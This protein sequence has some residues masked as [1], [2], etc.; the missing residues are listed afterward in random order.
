M[1]LV[2]NG[3]NGLSDVDGS[4]ATP[5]IRG[6]DANTGIF[7]PAADTIAFSEGGTE[8]MRID[9]S[10]NVG[11]GTAVAGAISPSL[12]LG[13]SGS[14]GGVVTA[15][16]S[17]GSYSTGY[18]SNIISSSD[19]SSSSAS[20]LAFGTTATGASGLS[21]PVE[22]MRID[23]SGN[24]LVGTT[25]TPSSGGIGIGFQPGYSTSGVSMVCRTNTA[26]NNDH[27]YFYTTSGLAGYIRTNGITTTYAS[28]SD[29][30]LKENIADA[31][32]AVEKVQQIQVR[33]FDWKSGDGHVDYGFIAQEL[34]LVAPQAVA[35]GTEEN[36]VWAVDS[37]MLV[38]LLVKAIQEQQAL[39]ITL[40]DRIT[41]L[42]AKP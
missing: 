38:P 34:N 32:S 14:G 30:R 8:A 11:V 6:T 1:T 21:A 13:N 19:F 10:G 2:L 36:D 20:Y 40:T 42:E 29:E 24:L 12:R 25:T 9:S 31:D 7:F 3:T 37:S 41:A 33:K 39:I 17:L 27:L 4:A 5:A 16:L 15:T 28:V 22:R 23:S 35:E 26:A 18:G